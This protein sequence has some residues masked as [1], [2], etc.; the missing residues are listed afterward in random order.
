MMRPR[1]AQRG[2]VFITAMVALVVMFLVGVT[3]LQM[4]TYRVKEAQRGLDAL[5]ALAMADAGL[6]YMIWNQKRPEQSLAKIANA[7]ILPDATSPSSLNASASSPALRQSTPNE[8][9]DNSQ[10]AAWLMQYTLPTSTTNTLDG[11]QVIAKGSYRGYTRTVRGILRAPQ[12]PPDTGPPINPPPPPVLDYALFS[13][14]G[15]T[16]SGNSTIRGDVGCNADLTV[17]SGSARVIGNASAGGRITTKKST[18]ISGERLESQPQ[19]ILSDIIQL[20]NLYA[21]A[22]ANG[23][24]IY[25]GSM[26]FSSNTLVSNRVIYVKGD[27]TINSNTEFSG[28]VTIV[29][30]GNVK[31]NG[32]VSSVGPA[33]SSNLFII[34]PSTVTLKINGNADINATIIAPGVNAVFD[35]SGS[36]VILGAVI[37]NSVSS[38]GAFDI[39]YR[40]PNV[41][42]VIVPP[43]PVNT[44]DDALAWSVA[45]WQ[46]L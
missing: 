37:A 19:V 5:N 4:S 16:I 2:I 15:L 12:P 33:D 17:D 45:A 11:Y 20:A 26:S 6:N 32:N 38:T 3:F 36:A 23:N 22:A 13:G 8:L 35:A 30:E 29:A 18:N 34:T 43:P 7:S 39:T 41:S 10:F 40:K 42:A 46:E 14:T 28:I 25:N 21:Y 31:I 44:G 27:V 24:E 1:N 9:P